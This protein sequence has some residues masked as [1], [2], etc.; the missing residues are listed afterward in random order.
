MRLD[1]E[2][3]WRSATN[4]TYRYWYAPAVRSVANILSSYNDGRTEEFNT[5]VANYEADL[6]EQ[7]PG[8]MQKMD[9]EV[10]FNRFEPPQP[11]L[12]IKEV[13]I[14]LRLMHVVAIGDCTNPR[15]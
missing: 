1:D 3:F 8:V 14:P 4:C 6:R 2:E 12:L 5:A 11:L 10:V 15:D 7:L 9:A 13:P